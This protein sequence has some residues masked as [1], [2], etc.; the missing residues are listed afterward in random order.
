MYSNKYSSFSE[1]GSHQFS[2]LLSSDQG[3]FCS[4]SLQSITWEIASL[5][6]I[7]ISDGHKHTSIYNIQK[8]QIYNQPSAGS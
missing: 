1:G 6:S 2:L 4:W 3:Y 8:Q 7:H 5:I